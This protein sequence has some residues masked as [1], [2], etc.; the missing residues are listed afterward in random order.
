[1]THPLE[2]FHP[3]QVLDSWINPN[4]HW[5]IGNGSKVSVLHDQ[6]VPGIGLGYL[7]DVSFRREAEGIL[8]P[9]M[10]ENIIKKDLSKH[11]FVWETDF[12]MRLC[13]DDM[14]QL[15]TSIPLGGSDVPRWQQ[16]Q[17]GK[18][19][20]KDVHNSLQNNPMGPHMP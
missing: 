3:T 20:I 12:L 6:W 8:I 4:I 19:N 10:V 14:L 17:V 5:V 7:R 2:N 1:M 13:E 15:T 18:C 11:A 16:N 9:T